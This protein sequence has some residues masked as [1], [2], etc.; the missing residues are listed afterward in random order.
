MK[1]APF[2]GAGAAA[3]LAGCGG[4]QTRVLPGVALSASK[5]QSTYNGRLV[6]EMADP[7]PSPVLAQPIIGEARRFDGKVAPSGWQLARGQQLSVSQ[8]RQLFAVL[9]TVAG[10][11]GK[12]AFKL[13]NPGFGV[14]VAVAGM[15]PTS[16]VMLASS[17][18]RVTLADSLG[19]NAVP[20]PPRMP[21]QASA[22]LI[23]ERRLITSGVRAA[24]ANPVRMTAEAV[25]RI[26]RARADAREAA[27]G[28]LSAGNRAQLAAATQRYL[29][30][31]ISL[32]EG[33]VQLAGM[34]SPAEVEGILGAADAM[35]RT[36]A[37]RGLPSL[38]DRRG[39]ASRFIFSVTVTNEQIAAATARGVELR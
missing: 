2:L 21:K 18:R 34:L 32:Y 39:E 20:A 19:P 28:V 3:F 7:I 37:S 15:L 9:G 26:A 11:D 14:I 5:A 35:T 6:P 29:A 13:P 17:A 22:Q 31:S 8:N 36:L 1:R 4:H 16:P 33:V 23:A 12:T 30:G 25:A 24:A 27:L 10:G 38:D